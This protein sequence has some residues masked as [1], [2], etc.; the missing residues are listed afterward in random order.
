[1]GGKLFNTADLKKRSTMRIIFEDD[2]L[3]CNKL[4]SLISF[5]FLKLPSQLNILK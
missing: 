3:D 1:M 4:V 2:H 5:S